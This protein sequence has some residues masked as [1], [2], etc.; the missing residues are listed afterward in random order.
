MRCCQKCSEV[1]R[2]DDA[3]YFHVT[4]LARTLS[5]G[6]H[7]KYY[8]LCQI[9]SFEYKEYEEVKAALD[10]AMTA[11]QK[12]GY[13]MTDRSSNSAVLCEVPHCEQSTPQRNSN[14]EAEDVPQKLVT[15][16]VVRTGLQAQDSKDLEA[17]KTLALLALAN[18]DINF[19]QGFVAVSGLF[20]DALKSEGQA[21]ALAGQK[22]F[23]DKMI[24]FQKA[25]KASR[26]K[27]HVEFERLRAELQA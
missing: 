12:L 14:T 18:G 24:K 5:R 16:N 7:Y 9:S 10:V 11:V 15:V 21:Y 4:S 17:S 27:A 13:Y 1:L 26:E 20:D 22:Q 2:L 25:A 3:V 8:P 6:L 19:A 23:K